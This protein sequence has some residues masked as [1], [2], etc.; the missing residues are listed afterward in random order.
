[1][2][3][4]ERRVNEHRRLRL[5]IA[6]DH[7]LF[8]ESLRSSLEPSCTVVGIISDG[9]AMVE[10]AITLRPD[11]VIA[12]IGMPLLNGLDAAR[13]IKE[14][15]PGMKFVFLTM[16][17]DPNLAAAAL[18][19]GHIAFVL[20]HSG[21]SELR[22]AIEHVIRGKI[23]LSPSLR[24]EDWTETR[25][26]ARQ[27]FTELTP[28][29]RDILQLFAEGESIKQIAERLSLSEKTVEFHKYHIMTAFNLKT[30]AA[31]VLFALKRGLISLDVEPSY[32][33]SPDNKS[34]TS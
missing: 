12:D 18:E 13:R 34:L 33:P 11:V 28:R 17:D 23:Y 6:D 32:W 25:T 20:K 27:F 9:R 16:H 29:Q 8:A 10:N 21:V 15:A 19:L 30:N 2:C 24:T 22:E 4:M 31:M 3:H 14:R 1:V 26:R 5:L 7:A